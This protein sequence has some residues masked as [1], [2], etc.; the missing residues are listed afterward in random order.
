MLL[1]LCAI[2]SE[3]CTSSVIITLLVEAVYTKEMIQTQN[4]I[5]QITNSYDGCSKSKVRTGTRCGK[6]SWMEAY[7][8]QL[9]RGYYYLLEKREDNARFTHCIHDIWTKVAARLLSWTDREVRKYDPT[10]VSVV[11]VSVA[12]FLTQSDLVHW[13]LYLFVFF[14]QQLL[15]QQFVKWWWCWWCSSDDLVTGSW[16]RFFEGLTALV[17]HCCKCLNRDNNYVAKDVMACASTSVSVLINAVSHCPCVH[18]FWNISY[19]VVD[20][21]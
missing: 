10:V 20:F 19:I 1:Q 17:S 3:D 7:Y 9:L 18:Y 11:W 13:D 8:W 14:R 16:L 4:T 21:Y 5:W 12:T 2:V 6:F 15:G